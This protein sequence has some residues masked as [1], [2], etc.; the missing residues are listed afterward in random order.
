MQP[1]VRRDG[2]DGVRHAAVHR[3][4]P[5]HAVGKIDG[6]RHGLR[7]RRRSALS[8]GASEPSSAEYRRRRSAAPCRSS[9]MCADS[10]CRRTR[11]AH[12]ACENNAQRRCPARPCDVSGAANRRGSGTSGQQIFD[13]EASIGNVG[14]PSPA[15]LLEAPPQQRSEFRRR[16][17]GQSGPV[18]FAAHDG[19]K[20]I[21]DRHSGKRALRRQHLVQQTTERPDVASPVNA[22]AHG[23]LGADVGNGTDEHAFFR[24]SKS[25]REIGRAGSRRRHP[26][27]ASRRRSPAP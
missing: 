22:V 13:F 6:C 27:R 8:G 21:R 18:G 19:A 11:N 5:S 4:R 10:A 15:I 14:E 25:Q 24:P 1:A 16:L 2:E 12:H 9:A 3:T 26:A 7:R 17:G 20:R 23:L